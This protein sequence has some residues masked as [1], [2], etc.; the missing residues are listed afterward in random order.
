MRP[1]FEIEIKGMA[2]Y[3]VRLFLSM[4]KPFIEA[5]QAAPHEGAPHIMDLQEQRY[6]W[7]TQLVEDAVREAFFKGATAGLSL[8]SATKYMIVTA[9][10]KEA[11]LARMGEGSDA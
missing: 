11:F 2:E 7:L 4:A 1:D 6:R 8:A 3:H 5:E 10:E 9:E